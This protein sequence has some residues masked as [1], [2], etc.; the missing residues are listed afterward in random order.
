MCSL[1]TFRLMRALRALNL[2]QT[3]CVFIYQEATGDCCLLVHVRYQNEL[4]NLMGHQI[5]VLNGLETIQFEHKPPK[6]VSWGE[7]P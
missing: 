7:P 1:V 4:L 6:K 5:K 3:Q 2:I